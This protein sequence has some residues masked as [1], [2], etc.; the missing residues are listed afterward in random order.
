MF[1]PRYTMDGL[2]VEDSMSANGSLHSRV[3]RITLRSHLRY[4]QPS[5]SRVI[6][7]SSTRLLAAGGKLPDG[8][9]QL[10]SFTMAKEIVA[11]ACSHAFFGESLSDDPHFVQAALEYPEDLFKTAEVLRLLPSIIAPIVAPILMRQHRASRV[12][13]E[14]LTPV[15][16]SRLEQSKLSSGFPKAKP[17]DCIQFFIDAN[18]QK[19]TWSAH[20]LIQVILGIWFAS[21]HQPAL[22]LA[23][24]LD[25]L[26]RYPGYVDLLREE[27]RSCDLTD[28]NIEDLPLLDGFLKESAR[29]H[30]SDSISV[31]RK[32]LQ[33]FRFSD[34][35]SLS[36]GDVACLPLQAI[37]RDSSNY[38]DSMRFDAFRFVNKNGAG[39][40]SRFTD[41]SSTYPLWGLG[42]RAWYVQIRMLSNELDRCTTRIRLIEVTQPGQILCC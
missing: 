38:P 26:C 33:P 39:N 14:H 27:L 40:T 19:D 31:R 34:G 36:V 42:K 6:H 28:E 22:S 10:Q 20:K 8:W 12:L 11:A 4:L 2:S 17:V 18:L 23:Y 37:M 9:T 1:Q 24:A 16:K 25:D 41:T 3:L 5:L 15:V 7:D 30:P 21:V 35:T 13:V 29:L 32:V